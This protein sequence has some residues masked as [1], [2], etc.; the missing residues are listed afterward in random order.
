MGKTTLLFELLQQFENSSRT[1]F[2][3]QPNVSEK[4]FLRSLLAD[5]GIPDQGGDVV[6]AH[7]ALTVCF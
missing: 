7:R 6:R 1:V 5:L 3:F 2:L 4:D